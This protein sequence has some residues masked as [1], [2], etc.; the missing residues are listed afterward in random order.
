[1]LS[2]Q[3]LCIRFPCTEHDLWWLPQSVGWW[4]WGHF[5]AMK[6]SYQYRKTHCEW[7]W[8]YLISTTSFPILI[9]H[10]PFF[11]ETDSRPS[12][13]NDVIMST[14]ASQITSLTIV[15]SAVYSGIDQRK[16]QSSS[17]LAFVRGIH[18][19]L[20]NSPHKGLVTQKMFSFDD[21]IM[22][23]HGTDR[24]TFTHSKPLCFMS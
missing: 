16:H 11:T 22:H 7:S 12:H 18:W 15:Y 10:H 20:V 9:I 21:I 24:A 17:S 3:I 4:G 8:E 19:Q 6:S 23:R 13:Y 5:S 1:M 14:M 2:L